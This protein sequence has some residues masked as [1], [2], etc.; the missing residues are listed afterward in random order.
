M[1]KSEAKSVGRLKQKM[2]CVSLDKF[3]QSA[4]KYIY[5]PQYITIFTQK[6]SIT[7]IN[8]LHLWHVRPSLFTYLT[9]YQH[10]LPHLLVRLRF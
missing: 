1:E 2:N 7:N 9:T 6:R 8:R 5:L 4:L 3:Y 10:E